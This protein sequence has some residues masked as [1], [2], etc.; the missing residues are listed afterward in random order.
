MSIFDR[1]ATIIRANINDALSKAEDPEK[2]INQTL[3]DMRQAQYEAR[4][5]VAK[6]IATG[7]KIERDYEEHQETAE[8]WMKKAEQ[9]LKAG[10]EDLAREAIKRKQTDAALSEGLK[11][12]LDSHDLMVDKLKTQLKALDAKIDEAE[13][14]R[15][16]LIA[17]QKRVEAQKALTDSVDT[18]MSSAKTAKALEAF[19]RMEDKL[20]GMEDQL[21]A[22]EELDE[23]LSLEQEL[24]ALG[25]DHEVDDE[26]S[27][28]KAQLGILGTGSD[29]SES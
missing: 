23:S 25:Y 6:A 17:R 27:A 15:V 22:R 24:D 1:V 4:M 9:A 12:Q 2:I 7:K 3:M 20:D 5:E 10:R 8:S 14:K 28:L 29:D 11:E 18:A 16:A 13:R 21:A 26:L 19:N